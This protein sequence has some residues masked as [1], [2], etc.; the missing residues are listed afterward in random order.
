MT[1]YLIII[2]II[3]IAL[4]TDYIPKYSKYMILFA[5]LSI[6]SLYYIL[7]YNY[8]NQYFFP[9]EYRGEADSKYN[10]LVYAVKNNKL[11]IADIKDFSPKVT[12]ILQQKDI[13]EKYN[14]YK[15]NSE[16]SRLFDLTLYKNNIYIYWGI[17][18]VL[19]FYLPFNLM[20]NLYLSDSIIVFFLVSFIF[21][22]SLLIM[23]TY[24]ADF[25]KFKI[26]PSLKIISV[27]VIGLCNY[28]VVLTIKSKVYEVAIACAIA[29]LFL[30]IFLFLKYLLV[31]DTNKRNKLIFCMGLLLSLA[32]GCRPHYVLFIPIFFITILWM[33]TK[34]KNIIKASVCFIL[35]CVIYG[36]IIS[37]YNYIRFDSIFEF[38]WKYQLNHLDQLN[39]V[40]TFKDFFIGLK[41]NLLQMPEITNDNYTVFSLALGQGHRIANEFVVGLIYV[42]PMSLLVLL[43]PF[44]NKKNNNKGK[45]MLLLITAL[46]LINFLV[47][48]L[49]GMMRR[50]AFEYISIAVILSLMIF[51]YLL[52]SIKNRTQRVII[53]AFF[54]IL[55]IYTIYIN[56]SLLFCMQDSLFFINIDNVKF[57]TSIIN[58]LFNNNISPEFFLHKDIILNSI[59]H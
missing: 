49:F 43:I 48:S 37:I 40:A 3:V 6:I 9:Q 4:I 30:S 57:Y 47:G 21:L 2:S 41:Y 50:Y 19:L 23:R 20:T 32:V 51:Y 34:T 8:A 10:N 46:F 14:K 24:T 28:A 58:F 54:T 7:S 29:L 59:L 33:E 1:L 38:G 12:S 18:P 52:K 35:P 16:I 25:L 36:S 13:Y 44:I 22:C 31:E 56:I 11:Y 55:I 5:V 45:G 26:N 39:Y 17:T 27:F 15:N 53:L 42:Y